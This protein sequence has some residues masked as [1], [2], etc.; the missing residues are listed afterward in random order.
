ME[1]DGTS[2]GLISSGTGGTKGNYEKTSSRIAFAL[3]E[4]HIS[5]EK[6]DMLSTCDMFLNYLE[7]QCTN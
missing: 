5:E 7:F 4:I 1:L 2:N 6:C 3:A